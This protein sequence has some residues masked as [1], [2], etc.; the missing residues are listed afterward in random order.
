MNKNLI[1]KIV[2]YGLIVFGLIG[3]A[4]AYGFFVLQDWAKALVPW[5]LSSL[6]GIFMASICA[7]SSCPMLWIAFSEEYAAL[8]GGGINFAV[9]FGGFAAFSFKIYLTVNPRPEILLFGS[10]CAAGFIA[11]LGLI[12]FGLHHTFR[13]SRSLPS[14]VRILFGFLTVNLILA[15]SLLVLKRPNIFPWELTP[16]QS[17]LYGWIFLGAAFYFLYGFFRPVW[18]NAHGQFLGFLAYDLVLIVPFIALLLS[19][20][21]FILP[22]LVYYIVVLIVSA[23]LAVYYLFANQDTRISFKPL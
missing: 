14:F 15:G 10:I 16:Q 21:P 6:S 11:T 17:V 20:K 18:G 13:N 4:E 3:L 22:N 1:T 9:M 19:K 23:L 5:E 2:R 7:A 12:Y 8:T